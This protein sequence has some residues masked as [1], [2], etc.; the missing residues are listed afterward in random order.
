MSLRLVVLIVVYIPLWLHV[1]PNGGYFHL[2]TNA[3]A[4]EMWIEY[5]NERISI[6]REIDIPAH[7][8]ITVG[9]N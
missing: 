9:C 3:I 6:N 2:S 4:G 8:M 7:G 1:V 5:G